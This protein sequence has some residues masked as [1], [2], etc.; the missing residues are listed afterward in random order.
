MVDKILLCVRKFRTRV[1]E[2]VVTDE[3]VAKEFFIPR[4]M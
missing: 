2:R 1:F 3:E 4:D